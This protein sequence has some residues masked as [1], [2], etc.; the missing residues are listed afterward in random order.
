MA[1]NVT[2]TKL[3]D[4]LRV[5]ARLSLNPAHNTD[6]R[7]GQ[8]KRLQREQTRLWEEHDWPHMRV[9]A[10]VPVQAGQ[11]YYAVPETIGE[12]RLESLAIFTDGV[13]REVVPGIDDEH[14]TAWNSDLDERSWPPRRW[15]LYED[16][17]IELWPIAD[18][19]ADPTT[20][21][22]Y[23]KFTGI[24]KLNPLVAAEDR[25]DLDSEMLVLFVASEMLAA[26][27]AKDAQLKLDK[28]QTRLARLTSNLKPRR[29]FRMF[30]IGERPEPQ[31]F[32]ISQ[33][34]RAG[35]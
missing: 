16:G 20:R 4:D 29:R 21:D 8:V 22:G 1:R 5:E 23:L 15:K 13:W 12:D 3:L 17:N 19:N 10:Q 26:S 11:R 27:G 35:T 32:T 33:Y 28:A 34:R 2:L 24:R 9:T 30:G 31:R 14:Y 6:A 25:C 18:S 7:A